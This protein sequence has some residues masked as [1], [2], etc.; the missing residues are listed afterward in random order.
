[1]PAR[2]Y[3]LLATL[4]GLIAAAAGFWRR[5]FG[6]ARPKEGFEVNLS[7]AEWRQRLTPAQFEVLRR[8]AT[9]PPFSSPL[10]AEKRVGT[11]HCA[12][13]DLAAYIS[14]TKFDSGTGWPSFFAAL[15]DA[16]RTDTDYKLLFPRHEVHCRRCGGHFGHVFDDGPPPSGQRHCINGLALDFRLDEA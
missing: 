16:V 1:M 11:Y 2:R 4:G 3:L 6:K 10:N 14:E 12:G 7:E 5:L 13:C 9:E 8:E 15:P